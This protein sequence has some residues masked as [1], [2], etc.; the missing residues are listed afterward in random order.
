MVG[1]SSTHMNGGPDTSIGRIVSVTGSKAI[2]LLDGAGELRARSPDVRPEMGTLLAIETSRTT[3]LAIVSALSVPVPSQ[4]D[5][6]SEVWIAEL[7]L[8]GE[9]TTA[10]ESKAPKFNRGVTGYPALGDRVRLA[11]RTELEATFCGDSGAMV[12]VGTIR[13]DST[14]PAMVRV[15]ELLGKHFAILGTTGTGKSCTTALILRSIVEK[16]PNAHIVLLDPHNEYATAFSEWAEVISPRN[17]Q[18]PYWLLTFEE[19]QEVLVGDSDR[20]AEI[21]ILQEVIPIAKAR[22]HSGRAAEPAKLRRGYSDSSRY[23]VDT[24][25]PYRISDLLLL[26]DE[27]LGKLENR[28]DLAPYRIL[29]HRIETISQDGRY[30]FMFGSLTVYDGMTQVLGRIFR[31]PVNNKPI[32][33]LE[34]TGIPSEVVNVVV[35]VLCRMT[36][37]FALWS[38]GQVPVTLVCEE[39]H[40]YVPVNSTLGFEPC[41]RAIAKIAKE[42]R[43]YGAS[44]CIVTQ[45]PAEIDPTILSQCNTVFAL[46]M[47]NDRDQEIVASAVADTGAGLLEF[48]PSLGQREAIAFG[49]GMALPVRI[50]FDE[51]PKRCLPKS[52]TA[53]FSERWQKSLG[54]D[55]FLDQIVERWRASGIPANNDG[56][57]HLAMMA[58]ALGFH[59]NAHPGAA[60]EAQDAA[61]DASVSGHKMP[62][63]PTPYGTTSAVPRPSMPLPRREAP[64]ALP[65]GAS[66]SSG[67]ATASHQG[68]KSTSAESLRSLRERLTRPLG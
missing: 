41:K 63:A 56:S 45:R 27:R 31:V 26:I 36:F 59:G 43:K 47:S 57:Q 32:T 13:Q 23:T 48:L 52:S 3:V 14:I 22:Y 58:D 15:D 50:K 44:L 37:D 54:D 17:M 25:V 12:R 10:G 5:G 42:G 39:A 60:P 61:H 49:D 7:G 62:M 53:N 65:S 8:V 4:R 6:D 46:R 29:K 67:A 16:N 40:R 35:S 68:A 1:T 9:L 28:K 21:E 19:L 11:L 20:K 30:A 18:L 24:P 66:S 2:V 64:P 33:I 34:L 38:E 51:L 55:G